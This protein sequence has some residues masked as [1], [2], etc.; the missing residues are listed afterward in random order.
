[1]IFSNP[2]PDVDSDLQ[3]VTW[4]IFDN[5]ETYLDIGYNL[6]LQQFPAKKNMTFW[7]RFYE[8]F[9]QRPLSTY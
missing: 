7:D 6:T 9:V 8:K 4:S 1:M 2:T 5:N 3:N